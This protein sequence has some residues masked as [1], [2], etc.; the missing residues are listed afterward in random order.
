MSNF[1]L[2]LFFNMS[3]QFLAPGGLNAECVQFASVSCKPGASRELDLR[4]QGLRSSKYSKLIFGNVII[5]EGTHFI[6]LFFE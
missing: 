1:D 5:V 3:K 4:P 6:F 2:L